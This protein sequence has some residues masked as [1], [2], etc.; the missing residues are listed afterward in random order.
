[1]NMDWYI[2]KKILDLP[3][4]IFAIKLDEEFP[5]RYY[6][7][8]QTAARDWYYTLIKDELVQEYGRERIE[9]YVDGMLFG[10]G[11][12]GTIRGTESCEGKG[13][14]LNLG[15]HLGVICSPVPPEDYIDGGGVFCSNL[16]CD[17]ESESI[18]LNNTKCP[19]CNR[20]IT[21][22]GPPAGWLYIYND[23]LLELDNVV[24]LII[25]YKK[26]HMRNKWPKKDKS[27][28]AEIQDDGFGDFEDE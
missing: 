21:S 24:D 7:N 8:D 22:N 18:K 19:K 12:V 2:V 3:E 15:K 14:I 5:D 13:F 1:M 25:E 28:R 11:F 27:G 17:F 9:N 4:D 26:N 16:E 20:R 6:I 10:A 23:G